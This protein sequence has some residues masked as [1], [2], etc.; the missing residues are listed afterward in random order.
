MTHHLQPYAAY[1]FLIN[2]LP[3]ISFNFFDFTDYFFD[4]TDYFVISPIIDFR[5]HRLL[6]FDFTD[7]YLISPIT[8][9]LLNIIATA[10]CLLPTAYCLL[11]T[12]NSLPPTAYCLLLLP[13][14]YC[15]CLLTKP[16]PLYIQ[17]YAPSLLPD[18]FFNS[19]TNIKRHIFFY[20]R[21]LFAL[22]KSDAAKARRAF[23]NHHHP[24]VIFAHQTGNAANIHIF[25]QENGRHIFGAKRAELV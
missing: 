11:P 20:F 22:V 25:T 12:A 19:I 7:Y 3:L 2:F 21:Q 13:T 15:Y 1:I 10:Y 16:H 23:L 18:V 6:V 8:I 4:F 14:A 24:D 5:F 9:I 17:L